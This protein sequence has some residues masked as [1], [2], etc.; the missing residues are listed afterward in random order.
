MLVVSAKSN[1][2]AVVSIGT[3]NGLMGSGGIRQHGFLVLEEDNQV[4]DLEGPKNRSNYLK[5]NSDYVRSS[6]LP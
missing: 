6:P 5:F 3:E 1:I 2:P 4:N